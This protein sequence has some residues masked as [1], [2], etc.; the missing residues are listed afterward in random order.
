MGHAVPVGEV[1]NGFKILVLTY[2]GVC[3]EGRIILQWIVK[4]KA[5]G[6]Q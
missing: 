2:K 3:V 6:V 1:R 4:R 5:H